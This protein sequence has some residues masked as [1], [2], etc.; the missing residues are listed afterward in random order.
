MLRSMTAFGEAAVADAG[1]KV[2]V[3]ARSLNHRYL[4]VSSRLPDE[5]RHLEAEVQR[6]VRDAVHRGRVE[7]RVEIERLD[8][9]QVDVRLQLGVL[10]GYLEA[11]E[12]ARAQGLLEGS[13]VTGDLLRLPA[14][15]E[16]TSARRT[17]AGEEEGALLRRAVEEALAQMVEGR[18]EEGSRLRGALQA[19]LADLRRQVEVLDE[20]REELQSAYRTRLGQRLA[21]LLSEAEVDQQR[22]AQEAA[23]LAERADVQEEIDRLDGHVRSLSDLIAAGG[24]AGKKLDFLMQEVM[25]ELNTIGAK[26]RDGRATDVVVDAKLLC[27][28]LREQI[29]NVE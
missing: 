29:Q 26:V 25:R 7:V 14:V 22:L 27:E 11:V 21:E 17:S 9:P 1:T 2:V 13:L 3:T 5:L 19:L 28:Q 4:D 8:E 18:I 6:I 10:R 23:L 15:V 20:L 12:E 16:V 24:V